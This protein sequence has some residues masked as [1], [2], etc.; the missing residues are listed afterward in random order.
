VISGMPNCG[1]SNLDPDYYDALMYPVFG[2]DANGNG[3]VKQALQSND[4]GRMNC[5]YGSTAM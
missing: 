5:L 2:F 4:E 1:E 3:Q